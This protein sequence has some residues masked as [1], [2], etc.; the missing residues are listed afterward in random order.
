MEFN[1]ALVVDEHASV[2]EVVRLM[3]KHQ[4]TC[5]LI[6]HN[7]KLSGIFTEH[8]VLMKIVDTGIN[9]AVRQLALT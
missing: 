1:R 6:T 8:D 3:R 7:G 9:L 2:Y 4:Q 5:V